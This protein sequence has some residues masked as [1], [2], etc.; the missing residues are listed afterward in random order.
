ME[1]LLTFSNSLIYESRLAIE[2]AFNQMSD[3]T[4]HDLMKW[5]GIFFEKSKNP[6]SEEIVQKFHSQHQFA[7]FRGAK[8][9]R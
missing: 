6:K 7:G 1:Y 9:T 3:I 4:C 8:R 5:Q 2:D